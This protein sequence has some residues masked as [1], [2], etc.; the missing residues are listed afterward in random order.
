LQPEPFGDR[1][2]P[3]DKKK[4]R[5]DDNDGRNPL[6]KWSNTTDE[7]VQ[8]LGLVGW[9]SK[10]ERRRAKSKRDGLGAHPAG[11]S[12]ELEQHKLA[13]KMHKRSKKK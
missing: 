8:E 3:P 11:P 6:L 2:I 13:K 12:L 10:R 1:P 4:R 9:Q 5:G 7:D